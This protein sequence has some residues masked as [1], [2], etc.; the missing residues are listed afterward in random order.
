[1]SAF[2]TYASLELDEID[3]QW[4]KHWCNDIINYINKKILDFFIRQKMSRGM[5]ISNQMYNWVRLITLF[6]TSLTFPYILLVKERKGH[7]NRENNNASNGCAE[8]KISCKDILL[9]AYCVNPN[10]ELEE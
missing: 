2:C 1:M 5:R 4:L 3:D 9:Y 8:F 10:Y 7:K 6:K